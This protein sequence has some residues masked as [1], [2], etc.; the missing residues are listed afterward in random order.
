MPERKRILFICNVLSTGG[1]EKFVS[2]CLNLLDRS[3]YDIELILFRDEIAYDIPKSIPIHVIHKYSP[4]STVA[5]I[6]KIRKEISQIKPDIVLSPHSG[7]NV[8]VGEAIRRL[9]DPP[10]WIARIGLDPKSERKFLER[11]W[12]RRV[13]RFADKVLV[14]SEALIERVVR[15]LRVDKSRIDL[16]RNLTD[17]ERIDELSSLAETEV[18][19]RS[20]P[21]VLAAGRLEKVKRYDMLLDAF[22][23]VR[24][25]CDARLVVL[26]DGSMREALLS[27]CQRLG[28]FDDVEFRGF[29]ANPYP[30]FRSS[31][32][33]VL[34]SDAEGSPNALIE[35]QGLGLPAVATDCAT[36]PAEIIVEGKTG[37]LVP[38]G[39][40]EV[41]RKRLLS[42]LRDETLRKEMSISAKENARRTF[43][44]QDVLT[45]LT[46]ILDTANKSESN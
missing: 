24:K 5:T 37:Y 23:Y 6:W 42:L 41:F 46:C 38:P 22:A 34:S 9:S 2:N 11:I 19:G 39:D 1:A 3:K 16:L 30:F 36:G 27:R 26:G 12:A 25:H 45:Q 28:I 10:F 40:L 44:T 31:D 15:Q 7:I 21:V 4:I 8:F 13:H 35:A 33:F 17:F 29:V 20:G 43:G 14:N 18:I 32:V